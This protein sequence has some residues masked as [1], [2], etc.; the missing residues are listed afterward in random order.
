MN[1]AMTAEQEKIHD[2]RCI[3]ENSITNLMLEGMKRESA[4]ALLA[5]QSIVRLDSEAK[6]RDLLRLKRDSLRLM[7][8]MMRDPR[9]GQRLRSN[10]MG[11]G[12]VPF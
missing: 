5:I 11:G 2:V 3:I 7:M 4:L 1:K 12:R 8:V 6:L 10:T 9:D